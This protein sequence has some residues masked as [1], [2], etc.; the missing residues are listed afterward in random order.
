MINLIKNP[1]FASAI[2]AVAL[3]CSLFGGNLKSL[4]KLANEVENSFYISEKPDAT[5]TIAAQLEVCANQAAALAS[6][7]QD[8]AAKTE[9]ASAR[10]EM[11]AQSDISRKKAALDKLTAAFETAA[12]DAHGEAAEDFI[13]MYGGASSFIAKLAEEYN[14]KVNDFPK[15]IFGIKPDKY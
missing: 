5:D 8:G 1:K 9:L 2:L 3:V 13:R 14:A 12:K 4:N 6:V 10:R 15:N 11:F 7:T